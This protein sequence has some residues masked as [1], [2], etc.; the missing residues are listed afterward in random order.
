[1]HSS[2]LDQYWDA[3]V[4][5]EHDRGTWRSTPDTA[6]I[7]STFPGPHLSLA[8]GILDQTVVTALLLTC[9]CA[10]TDRKNMKVAAVTV[11]TLL[12]VLCQ[13]SKQCV[14]LFIGLTVLAI[15]IS[16]GYNC[17][18]A[19]NPARDLAPRLFTGEF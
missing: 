3:L 15:G 2:L 9:V 13:V 12:S 4:W 19:I 5:Y 10:I 18:Y 6:G 1:M 7:F 11:V 17:G 16:F 14:P 8:G